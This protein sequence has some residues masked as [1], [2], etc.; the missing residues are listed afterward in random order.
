MATKNNPGRFDCYQNAEPDEPMF[1]LLGR[2]PCAAAAVLFWIELRRIAGCND[3]YEKINEAVICSNVMAGW[4]TKLGKDEKVQ[5]AYEAMGQKLK[6]SGVSIVEFE[7]HVAQA[8]LPDAD[9]D[10]H[11]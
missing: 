1:V 6:D 11:D 8:S 9:L 4:A 3:D 7:Q 2:D 10:K 5:K